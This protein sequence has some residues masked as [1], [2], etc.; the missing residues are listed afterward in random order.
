MENAPLVSVILPTFNAE[1]HLAEAIGS[2]LNQTYKNL[3]LI[4]LN[5][6]STDK[7]EAII[8]SF[9]DNRIHYINNGKNIGL[10]A[11]LNKGIELAK[12]KY[13]AR[14]DADDISLPTR[15]EK[16]IAF[17]EGNSSI[18]ACGTHYYL[19]SNDHFKKALSYSEPEVLRSILLFNS[20]L[21]HPSVMMLKSILVD[22]N[23]RYNETYKHAEDYDLW[24][25]I[26]K[27]SKLSNVQDFLFKYRSHDAQVSD[28]HNKAQ[29]SNAFIIR[30][31]YL[32]DLGIIFTEA[33]L[34]IHTIVAENQLIRS[35]NTL[36]SIEKWFLNLIQQNEKLKCIE[37]R[38]FN[39][40]MGKMWFDSCGITSMGLS[41][42]SR[43]FK[44]PLAKYYPL[45]IQQ[46]IKLA[47]KCIV[48]KF[49]K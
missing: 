9:N 48:R 6:G 7:T 16:Q 11:T 30:K 27:V 5:D 33:E 29:K 4:L 23:I 32:K 14:M 36:T 15:F 19:F 24:I 18:G 35:H 43:Y 13:I 39:Y 25:Q 37:A 12:G 3:E 34:E 47:A 46:R 2:I 42:Y 41:S 45:G 38:H 21:C 31:N 1:K 49:R 8:Q 17:M 44:S 10:V 28:I 40:W 26:S 22:S 20:C